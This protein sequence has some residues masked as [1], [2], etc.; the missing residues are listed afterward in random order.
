MKDGQGEFKWATGG[1]YKGNYAKDLKSGYGEMTWGDGS[2]YKG[3][4]DAG[5]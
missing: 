2:T 1:H 5:V 3:N 4:W